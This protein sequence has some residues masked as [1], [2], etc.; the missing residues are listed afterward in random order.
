MHLSFREILREFH[1][2]SSHIHPTPCDSTLDHN[3][4]RVKLAKTSFD[5]IL[6]LGA[7]VFVQF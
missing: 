4:T 6:D 3:T 1:I 7:D 5:E 2:A